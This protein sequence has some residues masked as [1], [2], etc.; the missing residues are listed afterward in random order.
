MNRQTETARSA[1]A[2]RGELEA[3]RAELLRQQQNVC[4]AIREIGGRRALY[5][6]LDNLDARIGRIDELL[7]TAAPP[8]TPEI[9]LEEVQA[10]V[11]S[12]TQSFKELLLA[13]PERVKSEF[14]RR[15]GSITLTPCLDEL[16]RVYR[17]SG[18]V[19]LFSVPEDVVQTNQVHLVGLHYKIPISFE[20][21][22]FRQM[23]RRAQSATT[24]TVS[25]SKEP[26]DVWK[27][28]SQGLN[29]GAV[30]KLWEE[31]EKV[32]TGAFLE[33]VYTAR[34]SRA[35]A[36]PGE[37]LTEFSAGTVCVFRDGFGGLRLAAVE[38]EPE[39]CECLAA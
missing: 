31:V 36:W 19:D 2:Q 26:D 33:A 25:S 11:D 16:G 17:V 35:F 21:I 13:S 7:A 10:F 5:E 3:N 37:N 34:H 12:Q 30:A 22:P 28:E 24:R 29:P 23:R 27:R 20:V 15:I 38:D 39:S 1:E 18:D 8:T 4:K 9:S 32:D 14:Q 6:D